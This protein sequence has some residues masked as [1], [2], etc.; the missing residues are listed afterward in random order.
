MDKK[1]SLPTYEKAKTF[2]QKKG[3]TFGKKKEQILKRP[4]F[5]A[6]LAKTFETPEYIKQSANVF[7]IAREDVIAIINE[8]KEA[9]SGI[10]SRFSKKNKKYTHDIYGERTVPNSGLIAKLKENPRN[11][12]ARTALVKP[13]IDKQTDV[14]RSYNVWIQSMVAICFNDMLGPAIKIAMQAQRNYFETCI[15]DC[16]NKIENLGSISQPQGRVDS[17]SSLDNV[18][19]LRRDM[20]MATNDFMSRCKQSLRV[21]NIRKDINKNHSRNMS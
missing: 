16:E 2:T 9:D 7:E 8:I 12:P 19:D 20:Y 10:L 14:E 3:W 1:T 17:K 18:D 5:A 6:D 21:H 4:S 13:F 15:K 11:G